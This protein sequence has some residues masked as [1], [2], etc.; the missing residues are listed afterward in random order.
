MISLVLYLFSGLLIAWAAF[1][2]FSKKTKETRQREHRLEKFFGFAELS[3]EAND[4]GIALKPKHYISILTIAVGAGAG[5]GYFTNNI[6]FIAVGLAVGIIVPRIIIGNYRYSKRKDL[7]FNL[8][9]NARL[10]TAQLRD[11]KSLEKA[12]NMS[13]PVMSGA[14]KPVFERLY[15]SL[16]LG[17][18]MD[19]ALMQARN[20]VKFRKFDDLCEKLLM[21]YNDGYHALSVK[22]IRQT[23]E[24]MVRDIQLLTE[25]DMKNKKALFQPYVTFTLCFA[26]PLFCAYMEQELSQATAQGITLD[27]PIGKILIVSMLI[28]AVIGL[29]KK[30]KY[31][32][33]NLDAL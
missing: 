25:I 2:L 30:D 13:L 4:A 14:T 9:L 3:R 12:L 23:I 5:A 32:R 17:V 11:S 31:L 22:S 28:V 33:L 6:L 29:W 1:S 20:E 21:G 8:P 18:P 26:F 19:R 10:V 16:R 15:T 27:T 7:L 24:E